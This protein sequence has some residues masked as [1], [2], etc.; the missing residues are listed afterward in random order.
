MSMAP[1][2]AIVPLDMLP[3]LLD[4]CLS[5][6]LLPRN[7]PFFPTDPWKTHIAVSWLVLW[8]GRCELGNVLQGV[9]F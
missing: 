2:R 5:V 7:L 8:V 6:M 3:N 4:Y 9:M 1:L